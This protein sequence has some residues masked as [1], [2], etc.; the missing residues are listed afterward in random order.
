MNPRPPHPHPRP[1]DRGPA[2]LTAVFQDQLDRVL[3]ASGPCIDSDVGSRGWLVTTGVTD[4]V[5]PF[6][7]HLPLDDGD[8]AR[9]QGLDAAAAWAL[10]ERLTPTQLS[11]RQNDAPTLGAMLRA[12]V[13][14]PGQVEVHGYLV[15][16]A[17]GDERI[18]AEG[19]WLYAAPD[20]D[21]GPRHDPGCQCEELWVIAQRDFG[22]G[23]A[24]CSPHELDRRFNSHRP[25]E[26][27]WS[28]WWD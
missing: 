24:R 6:V 7:S 17:R 23:D 28:L 5:G 25:S 26:P 2:D 14:H 8:L 13:A 21:I 3:A 10:L 15:G 9:F 12:A 18:T 11:D 4:V 1:G 19:V 22:L 20:L 16:P 27:C